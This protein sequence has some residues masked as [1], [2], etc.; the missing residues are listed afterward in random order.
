MIEIS[1]TE[2][3]L[4]PFHGETNFFIAIVNDVDVATPFYLK[5]IDGGRRGRRNTAP[6]LA[7][8]FSVV[9]TY[10]LLKHCSGSIWPEQTISNHAIQ[11]FFHVSK[12]KFVVIYSD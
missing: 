6:F 4:D 10:G 5:L 7:A 8:K 3:M 2:L 1:N 12:E 11:H 9:G